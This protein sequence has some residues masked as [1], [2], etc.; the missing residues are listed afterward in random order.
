[1]KTVKWGVLSAAKIG[2]EKVIPAMIQSELC[3]IVGLASRDAERARAATAKLGIPNAY[4][5]YEAM[6]ADPEIEAVY[7]PLPN[8]LHVDW[9]IKALEA[10]KHVLCEK[11]V[12]V[13][14][15]D[16]R[17]LVE[18]THSYPDLKVMEAFMYRF[19]PQWVEAKKRV[20]AGAIGELK[21]IQ[22]YFS[23]FND[24]PGNIRNLYERGG[25]G[26]LD[27]GCYCVS[28]SRYLF[29]RAP[30]RALGVVERDPD[31]R[32]DRMT[33][34]ILDFSSGTSSFTCSTQLS[35]YQRVQITG[36]KGR[37]EIEIPFNA[38]PDRQTRIWLET[39]SGIEE[40]SFPICDQYTL[41]GDAF[42]KSILEDRPVPTPLSDAVENLEVVDALFAS[43]ESKA[44]ISL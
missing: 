10:G 28:L 24:D 22:S 4:G 31:L 30:D 38:P 34:G 36:T 15:A 3:E 2:L 43:S 5:S 25:G 16:A 1:M 17:R 40:I 44:W 27:I 37:I 6:L 11:P 18:A 35:Y 39:E 19:H 7:N 26:L 12:G 21:S 32:I 29:G 23:Y 41:Q 42:S 33:S 8:H 14:S 20:D 13:D 9:T